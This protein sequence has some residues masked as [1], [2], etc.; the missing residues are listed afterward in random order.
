MHSLA[1]PW[2]FIFLP[3][4]WFFYRMLTPAMPQQSALKAPFFDELE[5][6]SQQQGRF[7]YYKTSKAVALFCIWLLVITA[8][9]RPQSYHLDTQLPTE[10]RALF[11]AVD[12]SNSMQ[13]KDIDGQSRIDFV[14]TFVSELISQRPSDNLGLILFASQPYL[15]SPL[16]Y[17]HKTLSQ[18]LND[19]Q[20]GMAGEHTAIGDAIGL[21]IKKLRQSSNRE[22]VAILITDG[23][24]N[25]GVMPPFTAATLAAELGIKVYTI[26]IGATADEPDATALHDLDESLL[27]TIATL[28]QGQYSRLQHLDQLPQLL[29]LFEQIE[30]SAQLKQQFRIQELYHWPLLAA[31]LLAFALAM[32]SFIRFLFNT[33]QL[34]RGRHG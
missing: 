31:V 24:N 7:G 25:S 12:I 18:W 4:P 23:A 10:G 2:V 32:L 30:P 14:K 22:K 9:A 28:T 20:P 21:A 6:L 11:L 17:D 29:T 34:K 19:A 15:Q 26:G 16:T 1:W 33:Q 13:I 5:Q 27:Q 3:L 8:A